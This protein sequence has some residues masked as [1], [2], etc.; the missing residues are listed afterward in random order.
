MLDSSSNAEPCTLDAGGGAE[1]MDADPCNDAGDTS[2]TTRQRWA[3]RVAT[4][5]TTWDDS[6]RA[7]TCAAVNSSFAPVPGKVATSFPWVAA[8]S[9][10]SSQSS[11]QG[12]KWTRCVPTSLFNLQHHRRSGQCYMLGVGLPCIDVA[13]CVQL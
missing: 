6:P 5:F 2:H 8:A 11:Y 13:H 4:P 9:R 12:A 7:D 1:G 10:I 3:F